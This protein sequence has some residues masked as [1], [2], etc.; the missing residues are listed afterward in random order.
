MSSFSSA[1]LHTPT[2]QMEMFLKMHNGMKF[3]QNTQSLMLQVAVKDSN[4]V[5]NPQPWQ[6]SSSHAGSIAFYKEIH[7]VVLIEEE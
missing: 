7:L 2:N 4:W 5:P 3:Y 1:F 6:H